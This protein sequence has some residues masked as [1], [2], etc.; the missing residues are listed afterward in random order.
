VDLAGRVAIVT[1]GAVGIGRAI[2]Q[3]L[4]AEGVT[5]VVADVDA[6]AESNVRFIRT[7]MSQLRD[8]RELFDQLES[9]DVLVNNAG[10]VFETWQKTI[11]VNLRS[12]LFAT[13]LALDTMRGDG[14]IVNISSVAAFGTQPYDAPDYAAAKAAVVR[15]TASFAN[16]EGVRVNCICPDWVDT[17][18]VQRSL[19]EMTEANRAEVP[20]LVPA[21]EIADIALDLIRDDEAAGR[22]VVRYADEP[23]ARVL[24]SE[25]G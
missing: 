4:A 9:L 21:A 1:G 20:P 18:A 16:S 5:V 6:P 22:V 11:D 8:V 15:F 17:P 12:L 19:A 7:D 24:S 23:G 3:R 2:A 13:Q 14:V 10:G 25:R